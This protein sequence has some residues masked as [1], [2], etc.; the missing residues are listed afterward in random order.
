VAPLLLG[1]MTLSAWAQRADDLLSEA[2]SLYAAQ[3]YQEALTTAKRALELGEGT[4]SEA[5]CLNLLA[6]INVRL[7]NYDEAAEYAKRCYALDQQSGD[8]DMMS[9]SL[10][11]LAAIYLGANRL[12]EA[13]E[14]VR[15]GVEMARKADNPGRMAVLLA[16]ASEVYHAEGKEQEALS[17]I[18]EAFRIDSM[19]GNEPRIMVR[20]AQKGSVLIGL[21]RYQEAERTLK[22]VVTYLRQ[23]PNRQ[24][25]GISCNKLGMALQMQHREQEA[26]SYYQEAADIFLQLGDIYNEVH[27]RKGLY[28]SLWRSDPD[29]AKR[30]LDRFNDLKDSI[31]THT[32]ADRLAKY[33]A[34]FGNDWL[35]I[36]NHAERNAKR[37]MAAGCVVLLLAAVAIWLLM[38][39]RQRQQQHI[40]KELTCRIQELHE[41]YDNLNDRHDGIVTTDNAETGCKEMTAA[42]REFLT[43]A[44]NTVN[45]L[46]MT[47]QVDATH[48]AAEMGMS[49]FQ[50]RQRL[51]ALTNETPQSFIQ[52]IRMKRARHLLDSHPEMTVSEI[53]TLC[54]YN[55]TPNFTRAFKKTFGLTPTQYQE[56]EKA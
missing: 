4:E 35:Q 8:P 19:S 20:L 15:R 38:R 33:S 1:A 9:S 5:D 48:V 32:S 39:R 37:L 46:I 45:E 50:L 25:L 31:Y 13:E 42:D 21:H 3:Q 36:E 29:E 53:A 22:K 7:S 12:E 51:S 54:A 44:V 47:G 18:D 55:D 30:Q 28:E 40:N 41:K 52:T 11:T 26:V 2:D 43:K 16:M 49:L 10:N 27:A 24:S 17:Y 56:Q 34:E 6:V 23:T 14:Y